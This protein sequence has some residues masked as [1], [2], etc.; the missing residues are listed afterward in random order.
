MSGSTPR[1]RREIRLILE[2]LRES[3]IALSVGELADI[4]SERHGLS[5]AP[6][7]IS[8]RLRQASPDSEVVAEG[9]GRGR[10]YRMSEQRAR[11]LGSPGGPAPKKDSAG[12]HD[13]ASAWLS[14]AGAVAIEKV[15][16][17]RGSRRYVGY[18]RAWLETYVPNRTAYLPPDI[19]D[20]LRQKGRTPAGERPA[21]T[22]AREVLARLLIDLSWA[23][24]QLEGNTYS[25]LDTQNLIEFGQRAA[26]KDASETQ[27]ILNHKAAIEFLVDGRGGTGLD[28][29]TLRSLH[30]LLAEGLLADPRDEGRLRVR[31][32]HITGTT[33]IPT[34]DPNVITECVD[35]I[36]ATAHAVADPFERS[37]FLLVHLPYLQPFIDVNKRTSRL[38]ANIPLMDHD[39]CPLT[40]VDVPESDYTSATLAIYELRA[41]EPMRDLYV[42]AYERS[43]ELYV[44][45]RHASV[46]PDP[47]RMRYRRELRDAIGTVIR[48]GEAPNTEGFARWGSEHGVPMQ[49]LGAFAEVA[50][51]VLLN[52]NDA[53]ASR[54]DV[55][56]SEF[57]AWR[58]KFTFDAFDDR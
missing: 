23:S 15:R 39:L 50:L 10:R 9:V 21:G 38:A 46:T 51:G 54:Y 45:A 37:F 27:M 26:G 43:A 31:P 3:P 7:A 48:Q 55:R 25:R 36:I 4:L 30:A 22:F 32:V 24:S 49:D 34:E 53:S 13:A 35:R 16:A 5:L 58:A 56:P 17:P 52:L 33:Y 44:V 29:R 11:Q 20:H 18:E 2:A 47:V 19:R 14:P 40:F 28:A 42:W 6:N 1:I 57:S 8:Y 12:S 41:T